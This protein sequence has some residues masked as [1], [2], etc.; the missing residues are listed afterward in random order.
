[1]PNEDKERLTWISEAQ[2]YHDR[3]QELIAMLQAHIETIPTSSILTRLKKAS[4]AV[5]TAGQSFRNMAGQT[6]PN[7]PEPP[8]QFSDH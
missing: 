6:K 2:H 1:M 3:L 4:T 5:E 7:D 8:N